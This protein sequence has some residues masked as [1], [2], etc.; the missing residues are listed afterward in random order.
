MTSAADP[1]R[2]C[3]G[4]TLIEMIVVLAI[5]AV[6]IGLVMPLFGQRGSGAE[7]TAAAGRVRAAMAG[8]RATAIAEGRP[9]VFRGDPAGG[10]WLDGRRR[11]FESASDDRLRILTSGNALIAFFPSGGSSGGRVVVQGPYNRREI[12]VDAVTGR[13]VALP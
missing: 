8:A 10:Y 1:D 12:A 11:G 5:L 3:G 13:A 6:A 4:F 2:G 9:V 7:L